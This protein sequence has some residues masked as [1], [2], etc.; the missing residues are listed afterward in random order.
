GVQ[1]VVRMHYLIYSLHQAGV[2]SPQPGVADQLG[3]FQVACLDVARRV[4]LTPFV[5]APAEPFDA[6]RHQLM[7]G[8]SKPAA[9]A[10]VD[11]TV[12]TGYTFQGR[13][14]RHALVK[15]RNGNGNGNG[16]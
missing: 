13:L 4:G 3:K 12:A 2:R 10:A 7:D 1:V 5:A 6:Q 8:E 11:E 9:D 15:L 16:N 14:I